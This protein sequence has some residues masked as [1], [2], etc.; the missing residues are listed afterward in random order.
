MIVLV[1]LSSLS[2]PCNLVII[3]WE[4]ADLLAHL[5]VIFT[6]VLVTFQYSVL[7]QVWHLIVLIPELCLLFY[8][9]NVDG[10]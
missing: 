7:D 6:C 4:R 1:M 3:R 5:C 10:G 9:E 2:V 8:F